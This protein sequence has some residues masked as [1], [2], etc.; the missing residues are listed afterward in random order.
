VG[1]VGTRILVSSHFYRQGIVVPSNCVQRQVEN[2]QPVYISFIAGFKGSWVGAGNK[3]C[4]WCLGRVEKLHT[5]IILKS[6]AF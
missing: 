2:E 5:I 3:T 4:F 6:F 1:G